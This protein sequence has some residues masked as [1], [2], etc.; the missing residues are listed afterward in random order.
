MPG[1]SGLFLVCRREPRK[2]P[3]TWGYVISCR[4][5]AAS[6]E[7]SHRLSMVSAVGCTR[8]LNRWPVVCSPIYLDMEI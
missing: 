1:S 5:F 4:Y 6:S 7:F 8:Q 3:V 2:T